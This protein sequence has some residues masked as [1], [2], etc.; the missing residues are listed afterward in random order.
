[1]SSKRVLIV[2]SHTLFREGLK[3]LLADMGN[4]V[5]LDQVGS[6]QKAHDLTRC[7]EVDIVI[8][9]Q[10]EGINH[11]AS[12]N[13]AISYLLALPDVRVI[14]VSLETD[15]MRVYKQERVVEAS[16]EDLLAALQD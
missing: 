7:D 4:V 16:V 9:D 2:S 14:S 5:V 11:Q 8:I 3:R 15:D 10:D 1:M 13:E 6:L 12:R